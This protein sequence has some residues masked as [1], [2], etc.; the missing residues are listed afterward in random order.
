MNYLIGMSD[1]VVMTVNLNVIYIGAI[2][3]HHIWTFYREYF[4]YR[5]TAT[6]GADD[7][8]AA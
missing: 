4:L 7:I 1:Y 2:L 6:R 3:C 8:F 5:R